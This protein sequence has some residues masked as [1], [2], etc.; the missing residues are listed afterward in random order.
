MVQFGVIITSDVSPVV[1][2]AIGAFRQ[3][4]FI[5]LSFLVHFFRP[6]HGGL[7]ESRSIS[8]IGLLASF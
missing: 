5:F 4:G 3:F 2:F 6:F 8:A 1:A 7:G